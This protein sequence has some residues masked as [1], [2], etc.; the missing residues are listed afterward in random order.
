[1][2]LECHIAWQNFSV[3]QRRIQ[4][5]HADF[6]CLKKPLFL[7]PQHIGDTRRLRSQSRIGLTHHLHQIRHQLVKKRRLL[8]QLVAMANRSADDAALHVA[9]AFVGRVHAVADE[10]RG[11]TDMV[12]NDAQAFVG[13]VYLT[14][15]A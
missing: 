8:A 9:T 1:M 15:L 2:Q 13:Q 4:N 11:G 6:K 3:R 10:E 5:L 12:G 14:R 7:D